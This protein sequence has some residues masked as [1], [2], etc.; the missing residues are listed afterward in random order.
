MGDE[1]INAMST[2][3]LEALKL[4]HSNNASITTLIDGILEGRAKVEAQLAIK[5]KF[6]K[7]ITKIVDKLPHPDDVHN[8]LLSWREVDIPN[9]EPEEVEV[10]GEMV[11]R[12]P[13]EKQWMY[14]VTVNHACKVTSGGNTTKV[15][16]REVAIFKHNPEGA[17]ESLGN[18]PSYADFAKHQGIVVGSDSAR[19]AVE[20]DGFYG[21]PTS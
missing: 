16:K 7:D 12:Q 21:K 9:G 14:V 3:E 4:K 5:A 10:D 6:E 8:I 19:R 17:D 2:E 15:S 18:F 11:T 13:S 1:L 20:R